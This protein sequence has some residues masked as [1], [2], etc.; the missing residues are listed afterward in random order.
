MCTCL[1]QQQIYK[2]ILYLMFVTRTS[3]VGVAPIHFL[4][5]SCL[6]PIPGGL[7]AHTH[8][9]PILVDCTLSLPL[10]VIFSLIAFPLTCAISACWILGLFLLCPFHSAGAGNN[11]SHHVIWCFSLGSTWHKLAA[12][13]WVLSAAIPI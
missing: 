6:L 13:L 1:I 3:V 8:A 11:A 7:C 10:L 12:P 9:I 4:P 5:R 2:Y